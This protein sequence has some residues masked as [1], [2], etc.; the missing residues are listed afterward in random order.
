M[1]FLRV[2]SCTRYI[3]EKATTEAR[4]Y[5]D[6]EDVSLLGCF[7]LGR[8]AGAAL[9]SFAFVAH[10]RTAMVQRSY[11]PGGEETDIE[12]K[13]EP[14]DQPQPPMTACPIK[15][16]EFVR[17]VTGTDSRAREGIGIP[18][19]RP[20]VGQGQRKNPSPSSRWL[21][22]NRLRRRQRWTFSLPSN[23]WYWQA[24][25]STIDLHSLTMKVKNKPVQMC[26]LT[27]QEVKYLTPNGRIQAPMIELHDMRNP[28]PPPTRQ[29]V[30]DFAVID[31]AKLAFRGQ[32]PST[33]EFEVKV[34]QR[35]CP[36]RV[37][38]EFGGRRDCPICPPLLYLAPALSQPLALAFKRMLRPLD[39][40]VVCNSAARPTIGLKGWDVEGIQHARFVG[41][42]GRGQD[43]GLERGGEWLPKLGGKAIREAA[44][45]KGEGRTRSQD[46]VLRR[47]RV[48]VVER[49]A[50]ILRLKTPRY[51]RL[52]DKVVGPDMS[53]KVDSDPKTQP[54]KHYHQQ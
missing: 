38:A 47:P 23:G 32:N 53:Y 50:Q 42:Q 49:L 20:T 14:P 25:Q 9:A 54:L 3:T 24:P 18:A 30:V 34:D 5:S 28:L 19:E 51:G 10:V 46:R 26:Q 41:W 52:R 44:P 4:M 35:L 11:N 15:P 21:R 48:R 37:W 33:H 13:N 7:V 22:S 2:P 6:S 31:T 27:R 45:R 8:P 36:K 1:L 16:P 39:L 43:R 17:T 29:E 12:Q 40:R